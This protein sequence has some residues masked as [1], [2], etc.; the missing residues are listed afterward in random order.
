MSIPLSGATRLH[1]IVG[2]PIAQVKSPGGMTAAFAARGADAVLVPV[3]V[4]PADIGAFFEVADRMKNLDGLIATVPHKFAAFD[5]CRRASARASF[6]AAANVMRREGDGWYGDMVDGEGF[7]GA[8]RARG[9]DPRGKRA[10]LVGAGGAGSAIAY[11]LMQAG[12]RELAI[13]DTDPARR[14][15]LIARFGG[16][17]VMVGSADPA[18]FDLVCNATPAGMRPGDALPVMTERLTHGM[19]VGCVVT[20]PEVSPLIEAARTIGCVTGTGTDMYRALQE[21]MVTFLLG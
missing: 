9:V 15:T 3:Q 17:P 16:A 11:A 14:D 13:H 10:L 20:A 21:M 18:G 2:D 12:V 4:G 5:H 6:I 7:V 19:Y 1:M 8:M